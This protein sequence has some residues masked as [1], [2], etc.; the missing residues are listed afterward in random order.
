VEVFTRKVLEVSKE[1]RRDLFED[2]VATV[3]SLIQHCGLS[4]DFFLEELAHTSDIDHPAVVA[5]RGPVVT[6]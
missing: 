2:L 5:M 6:F 1:S 3:T 4:L